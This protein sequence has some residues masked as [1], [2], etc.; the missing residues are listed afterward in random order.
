MWSLSMLATLPLLGAEVSP[1]VIT[2]DC[3][4]DLGKVSPRVG[5][6]GGLRDGTPDEWL[7][8]LDISLWRI[9]HQFRGRVAGGLAAAVD[10][11]EGLG[12]T[13]KLV[14]S[15][16]VK[17]Q[18]E[19][20][21]VYEADVKRLVGQ[22]GIAR[23]QR[24]IWAPVNEPDLSHKPIEKQIAMNGVAGRKSRRRRIPAD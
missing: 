5:F 10:R 17:S 23:A 18:P 14:M 15:D 20:W 24:M 19:D 4:T 3:A 6:L 7:R 22:V 9:G 11:V 21:G 8:P 1:V 13:Y 16:L 2:I 12:A